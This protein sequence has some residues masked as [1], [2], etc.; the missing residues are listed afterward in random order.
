MDVFFAGLALV[1]GIAGLSL[2][3]NGMMV[4][5]GFRGYSNDICNVRVEGFKWIPCDD[6]L[7][8][9][10]VRVLSC[11]VQTL[12]SEEHRK[13]EQKWLVLDRVKL[14]GLVSPVARIGC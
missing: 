3:K 1:D 4:E 6:G 9:C 14:S 12:A 7:L 8:N 13:W 5:K 2:S 11:V 10:E